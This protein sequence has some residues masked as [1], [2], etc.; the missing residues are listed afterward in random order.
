[1]GSN[2]NYFDKNIPK[3]G[4]KE[5]DVIKMWEEALRRNFGIIINKLVENCS[6]RLSVYYYYYYLKSF[7]KCV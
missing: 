7:I 4:S 2:K 5:A 3:A 1:M 6:I